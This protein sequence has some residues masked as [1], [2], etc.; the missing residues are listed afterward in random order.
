[1][2]NS[3]GLPMLTGPVKSAGLSIIRTMPSIRSST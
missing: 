1:M 3:S 2:L